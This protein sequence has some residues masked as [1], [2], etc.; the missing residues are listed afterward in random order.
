MQL[1][2]VNS[3]VAGGEDG[4]NGRETGQVE[5]LP[6][7]ILQATQANFPAFGLKFFGGGHGVSVPAR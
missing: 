6:N 5:H 2:A 1:S 3:L 4:K 7:L